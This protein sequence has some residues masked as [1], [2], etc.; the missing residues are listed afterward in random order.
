MQGADEECERELEKE[1][2]EEEESEAVPAVK[3]KPANA[4]TNAH[5]LTNAGSLHRQKC[6]TE[7]RGRKKTGIIS[8]CLS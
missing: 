7:S 3:L 4:D 1:V 8:K 6:H 5:A 2:E